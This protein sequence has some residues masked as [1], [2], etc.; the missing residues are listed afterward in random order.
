MQLRYLATS[1]FVRKVMVFALETG[2]ADR[3]ERIPTDLADP[4]SGL[5]AFNPL[6]KV[7]TLITDDGGVL[8]DSALICDY[9]DSVHD[10]PPRIPPAGPD[11]WRTLQTQALAD[12][13]LDAGVL[14]R[15][16]SMRPAENQ[17]ADW[18]ARQKAK[19]DRGLDALEREAARFDG[20][21]EI[22]QIAAGCALGWLGFRFGHDRPLEGRSTLARWYEAFAKRPSMAATAPK[23]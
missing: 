5:A 12:G 2:L 23:D 4:D 10:G 1:P 17:S 7:P 20:S 18:D 15:M 3:I 11:R 21:P 9:L 22:G 19:V 6:G 14:R 16:E 8:Y 13:V